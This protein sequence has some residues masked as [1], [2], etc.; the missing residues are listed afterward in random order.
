MTVEE[1]E[2]HI[3]RITD[4]R[5]LFFIG[6]LV[7]LVGLLG[8][9]SGKFSLVCGEISMLLFAVELFICESSAGSFKRK[10]IS[11]DCLRWWFGKSVLI[12]RIANLFILGSLMMLVLKTLGAI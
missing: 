12:G 11:E 10:W 1:I 6:Y 3:K 5:S 4:Q 8:N 9:T 7:V 2:I